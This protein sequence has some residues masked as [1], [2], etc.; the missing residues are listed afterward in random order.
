MNSL[1]TFINIIVNIIFY[2]LK[3]YRFD[4]QLI[5]EDFLKGEFKG[6]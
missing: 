5:S 3:I 6:F 4:S 1:R 2:P